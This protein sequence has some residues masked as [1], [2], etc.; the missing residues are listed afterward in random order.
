MPSY[1]CIQQATPSALEPVAALYVILISDD[2]MPFHGSPPLFAILRL[3]TR[4]L[5][6]AKVGMR[7]WEAYRTDRVTRLLYT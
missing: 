5:D 4:R 1:N 3:A 7:R 6:W 2:N